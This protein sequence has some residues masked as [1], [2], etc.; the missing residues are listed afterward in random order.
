MF[1]KTQCDELETL[2]ICSP[3]HQLD[4][5]FGFPLIYKYVS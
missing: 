1:S 2:D 5:M 3:I 4:I